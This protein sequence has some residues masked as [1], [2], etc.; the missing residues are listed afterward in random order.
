[1]GADQPGEVYFEFTRV[2]ASVKVVAIDGA[3]GIEV[4]VVGPAAAAPSDLERLALAKLKARLAK[5]G[6]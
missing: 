4:A 5:E 1:M 6:E 2:G 3:T